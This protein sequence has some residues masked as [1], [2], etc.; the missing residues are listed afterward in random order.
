MKRRLLPKIAA[1]SGVAVLAATV[2]APV[3]RGE[4]DL[5]ILSKPQIIFQLA[6]DPSFTKR[7]LNEYMEM[8]A[9]GLIVGGKTTSGDGAGVPVVV[10]AAAAQ[11]AGFSAEAVLIAQA[12]AL[13]TNSIIASLSPGEPGI[14]ARMPALSPLSVGFQSAAADLSSSDL[15][16]A[17]P[18]GRLRCGWYPNPKPSS[19]APWQIRYYSNTTS[20]IKAW[21]FHSTPGLVGGGW[22]RPQTYRSISCGFS[23]FRDHAIQNSSTKLSLQDYI[24]EPY[25]EPNPEIYRSGPWPYTD[26][27]IYVRWWH[28]TH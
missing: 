7:V 21:G 1:A 11:A 20:Q 24:A 3:A 8:E 5:V 15:S 26:W 4:T 12:L 6:T 22:T 14:T 19:A 17:G 25:G 27:P 16:S 23:T 18:L 10:Y 9:A 2:T 28:D 13:D